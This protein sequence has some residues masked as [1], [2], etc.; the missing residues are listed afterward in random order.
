MTKKPQPRPQN[1][2]WMDEFS[3]FSGTEESI[4]S[5]DQ[6]EENFAEL[7]E[8][9]QRQQEIKEG[10]VVDGTVVAVGSEYATVDIGYK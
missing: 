3:S 8:A 9:S 4:Q 6:S 5:P 10:E 1:Q 7:F 2:S